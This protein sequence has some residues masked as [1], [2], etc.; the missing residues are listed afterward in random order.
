MFWM[1][2]SVILLALSYLSYECFLISWKKQLVIKVYRLDV[3]SILYM[4]QALIACFSSSFILVIADISVYLQYM[5]IT[6][7]YSCGGLRTLWGRY[8]TTHPAKLWGQCWSQGECCCHVTSSAFLS[9]LWGKY[10]GVCSSLERDSFKDSERRNHGDSQ[11]RELLS[12]CG[13]SLHKMASFHPFPSLSPV[14]WQGAELTENHTKQKM[15]SFAAACFKN[16]SN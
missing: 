12:F 7:W 3:C 11:T 6:A 2:N 10:P 16:E 4:L 13:P 1:L 8:L 14:G 9:L 5:L 15:D